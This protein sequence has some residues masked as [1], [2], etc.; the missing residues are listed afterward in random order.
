VEVAE[1]AVHQSRDTLRKFEGEAD[2]VF[3][4]VLRDVDQPQRARSSGLHEMLPETQSSK[5]GDT[6]R[7]S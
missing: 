2:S 4:L 1:E 3:H 6:Y 5:I 7:G